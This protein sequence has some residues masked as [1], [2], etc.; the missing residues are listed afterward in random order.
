MIR[1]IE[2]DHARMA[3]ACLKQIVNEADDVA[4]FDAAGMGGMD[5]RVHAVVQGPK[6]TA[7]AV[8]VRFDLVRQAPW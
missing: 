6:D 3:I 8:R 7:P 4:A 2:H 5:Q 1:V